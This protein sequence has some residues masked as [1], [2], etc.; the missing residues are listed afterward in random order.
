MPNNR[1]ELAA[2]AEKEFLLGLGDA[3]KKCCFV[4]V[5]Q[6]FR[7]RS[8]IY[9]QATAYKAYQ[10][11]EQA[12]RQAGIKLTIISATRTF[13]EQKRIWEDKWHGREKLN[14]GNLAT[15]HVDHGDRA[16]EIL[17]FCAMPGTSRHHWGTDIDLNRLQNSYF[18]SGEGGE[19]YQ[20]L[21]E[22]GG[23][24]GFYQPYTAH[25]EQRGHL[26]Y[27][28]EKWHWSYCPTAINL[29]ERYLDLIS[30]P[31]L[32]GFTGWETAQKLKVINNYVLDINRACLSPNLTV[33]V[34]TSVNGS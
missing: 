30:Y 22:N 4:M 32:T 25:G 26:G 7:N 14:G 23:D 20:W 3:E 29:L 19:V 28:E 5:D 27:H 10:A 17:R 8:E 1:L 11:M 6:V 33:E 15:A 31:D 18:A 16:R 2:K 21:T 34:D 9:L 13:S 12:A 24:Y